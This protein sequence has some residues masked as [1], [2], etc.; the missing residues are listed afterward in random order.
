M[1][2][3][4]VPSLEWART[5]LERFTIGPHTQIHKFCYENNTTY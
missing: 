3:I 1:N 5:M 4:D 2:R